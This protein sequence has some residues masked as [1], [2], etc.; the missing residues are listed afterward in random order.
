MPANNLPKMPE[1]LKLD[2]PHMTPTEIVIAAEAY[3]R[4]CYLAGIEAAKN[5]VRDTYDPYQNAR[6]NFEELRAN[7]DALGRE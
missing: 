4:A 7:L 3:G 5:V 1:S 6:V 2:I